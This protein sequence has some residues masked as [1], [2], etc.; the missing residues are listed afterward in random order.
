MLSLFQVAD[1]FEIISKSD[2]RQLLLLVTKESHFLFNKTLYKQVDGVAMGSQFWPTLATA[3]LAFHEKQLLKDCPIEFKPVYYNYID[4]F[5]LLK[6][7]E[8]LTQF[9]AS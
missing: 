4:I 3:F 6:S 9:K 8:H 1:T 5:V 7:P 2:L